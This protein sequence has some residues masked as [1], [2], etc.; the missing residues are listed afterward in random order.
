MAT[1]DEIE[2]KVQ[3][4]TSGIGTLA[5]GFDKAFPSS[6]KSDIDEK[7]FKGQYALFLEG[8]RNFCTFAKEQKVEGEALYFS[9]ETEAKRQI[10]L[11]FT[12]SILSRSE[13]CK[14]GRES[15][16]EEDEKYSAYGF[17]AGAMLL[18]HREINDEA[19]GV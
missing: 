16:A 8:M 9:C 5:A 11:Y 6:D 7:T 17:Y 3:H 1:I 4:L 19:I 18:R 14:N 15:F 2:T 10:I 12:G 13:E